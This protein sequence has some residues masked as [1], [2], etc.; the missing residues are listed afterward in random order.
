MK[1][2]IGS[3]YVPYV[4]GGAT[5]I[6]DWLKAK[7]EEYGHQ[8]EMLKIPFLSYYPTMLQQMK[9]IRSFPIS[10]NIDRFIAIRPPS[11]LVK[12]PQKV[13]WF[14][15]HHR[16]AYD[17]WGTRYQDIPNTDSG[18]N[19]RNRMIEA[20]N[21]AFSEAKKIFA[22][23][24]TV[25]NRL[26]T[27]NHIDAEVLYP[28]LY[29]PDAFYCDKYGD[30]LFYP[31]RIV[32]HKRQQLAIKAMKYTRSGV[33]LI[34]A[35][36]TES[37]EMAF[38]LEQ[39]IEKNGLANKVWILN[40][41]ITEQE[42]IALMAK[43]LSCL[44]IPYQEDSYGYPSLEAYYSRKPVITC[45]DSGGTLELIEHEEN[46]LVSQPDPKE[47]AKCFDRL[48]FSRKLA[49]KLGEAGYEKLKSMDISWNHVVRRL[50][51]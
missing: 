32:H 42:K 40:R 34:I 10:E 8:T 29:D 47:L 23:S 22:N 41:W 9:A 26:K 28:P 50:L 45:T 5:F 43:A 30:F 25:K 18:R 13:I 33:K 15:H 31:S 2:L 17:F 20:D 24:H 51:S 4:R 37:K 19:I 38:L 6:A 48:Y 44:Y 35:G 49:K 16:G 36:K 7:L 1:I 21:L 46:G 14:I 39:M 12:H 11:Y 27:F 3:T